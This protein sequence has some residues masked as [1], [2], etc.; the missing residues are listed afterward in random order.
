MKRK[1]S[2][3]IVVLG[4]ANIDYLVRGKELPKPGETVMGDEFQEAPGGKGA[5]QAIAATR[6]GTHAYFVG[7]IGID[8]QGASVIKRL[9]AEGV[10]IRYVARDTREQ[11]GVALVLVGE[12]GEK[13]ILTAPGAN[14]RCKVSDI[15]K[16][17]ETIQSAKILL[18]QLELPLDV[19]L[20]A[21]RIAHKAGV[22]IILDPSPPTSLPDELLSMVNVIKPNSREAEALTGILSTDRD[23]AREAAK[24]LLERGVGAVAVQAGNEANMIVTPEQEYWFPFIPVERVDATG[25]G[26]AFAAA[27]AVALSE[28]RPLSEAGKWAN[29]A[30]AF[31]TTK[32]GAQAGLPTRSQVLKLLKREKI[33]L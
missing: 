32:L 10:N 27:L 8:P 25:A 14:L 16:A 6:L 4:G 29:A 11:T 17:E 12:S 7:R 19:L 28:D 3:H 22:K 24:R 18:M 15:R 26:D 13:Q 2:N 30:A 9:K 5:N 1:I 21:A 31:A 33:K 23:A 20:Y